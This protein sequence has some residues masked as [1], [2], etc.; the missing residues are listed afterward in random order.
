[1]P[2]VLGQA[3]EDGRRLQVLFFLGSSESLWRYR[4]FVAE[5]ARRGHDV[6]LVFKNAPNDAHAR[7]IAEVAGDSGRV[8]YAETPERGRLDGWRSVAWMVRSLADLARYSHP[9][10]EQ[11]P[12]LRR[13]MTKKVLRRLEGSE[14]LEPLG[15]RYALRLARRLAS[16]TD[17]GLSARVIGAAARLE[18]A[19]PTSGAIDAAIRGFAPDVVL[20]TPMIRSV[21]QVDLL[22]SARRLRIPSA[23]CV[24]S[25]DN[26][27]NK[28]L[29]K[30]RPERVFVWNEIQRREAVELHGIPAG[31]VV[32]TGSQMFDEWFARKP[33]RTREDFMQRVGLRP[34]GLFLLYLCSSPFITNYSDDEVQFVQEWIAALR[35]SSDER[36]RTAGV[37]VRPHPNEDLA[38]QWSSAGLGRLGNVVVYPRGGARPVDEEARADYFDSL[39]HSAAVVGINT[40]AMIEAAIVGRSV[41]TILTP[42]LAQEGTLHFHY[43]LGEQGGFLHVASSLDEHVAQLSEVLDEDVAGAERRRRFVESFVRPGGIDR[44]AAPIL[45]EA[46]EELAAL[47]VDDRVALGSLAL[48]PLLAVEAGL[49]SCAIAIAPARR[50]LRRLRRRLMSRARIGLLVERLGG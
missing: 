37:L 50:T 24:R 25:W 23:I 4:T 27:T 48:R 20:A 17:A 41:L 19:I 16:T 2:H 11:A 32:A 45:A 30:F 1:V 18:D 49:C 46:V 22:K 5:L 14:E 26:L 6:R 29:L 15:R 12:A 28:G 40:T 44:P 47:P 13:R 7:L 31:C 34:A 21:F 35:R 42:S 43:L 8:S 36:L 10:Y 33:A 9:R 3:T 39:Y 38:H